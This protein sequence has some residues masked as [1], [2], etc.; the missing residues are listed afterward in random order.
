MAYVIFLVQDGNL[1]PHPHSHS[2]LHLSPLRKQKQR[3]HMFIVE[4]IEI[5]VYYI[6]AEI[7][8]I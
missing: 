6:V 4:K 3:N 7:L 5:I 8:Q 2:I 1:T